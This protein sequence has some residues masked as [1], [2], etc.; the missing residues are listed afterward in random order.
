MNKMRPPLA[1]NPPARSSPVLKSVDVLSAGMTRSMTLSSSSSVWSSFSDNNS[2]GSG[3]GVLG[4][5][6]ISSQADPADY[7]TCIPQHFHFEYLSSLAPPS[8]MSVSS[9]GGSSD[10]RRYGGD[11]EDDIDED[12]DVIWKM[13][14][15]KQGGN[16]T[17]KSVSFI[18]RIRT[19]KK[20][21]ISN[22]K[23]NVVDGEEISSSSETVGTKEYT[24]T[25]SW[26]ARAF[27]KKIPRK[28]DGNGIGTIRHGRSATVSKIIRK[29][30]KTVGDFRGGGRRGRRRDLTYYSD[31]S[32][33]DHTR[34]F[35]KRYKLRKLLGTGGFSV[36][37]KC[38][39]RFTN[40]AYAVKSV[41]I[42]PLGPKDLELLRSEIEV[43]RSLPHHPR[44]AAFIDVYHGGAERE[45][46]SPIFSDVCRIIVEYV[47]GGDLF[48]R[49]EE[50]GAYEE[51][52][53]RKICN[54]L[55]EGVKVCHDH[56][57]VH[58]DLKLENILLVSK[59]NDV[60]IKICDFGCAGFFDGKKLLMEQCGTFSYMAPEIILGMPYGFCVD[61]WS[62]GVIVYAILSGGHPFS[63]D[64]ARAVRQ[65]VGGN[66]SMEKG[67]W[68]HI[69]PAAKEL[70]RAM[71]T[72]EPRKRSD[73]DS[74]SQHAWLRATPLS[75][76]NGRNT[77]SQTASLRGLK[78]P[79]RRTFRSFGAARDTDDDRDV[80]SRALSFR[81]LKVPVP[82]RKMVRSLGPAKDAG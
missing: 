69:S 45:G 80:R 62:L 75:E 56:G 63:D 6:G 15:G 49:L 13:R 43:L 10:L 51:H 2:S 57:I 70:V 52:R 5:G 73:I 77:P 53:A 18:P 40:R 14:K 82:K 76:D 23:S 78:V 68:E 22:W 12:E 67:S 79:K 36:V 42:A 74:L 65:I 24:K 25:K 50:K 34:I 8:Y 19:R 11:D 48:G 29:A 30:A 16:G 27:A 59:E 31:R 44:I 58:R 46:G 54:S 41:S 33:E 9:A 47:R 38:T 21:T 7:D 60:D 55:F 71:L 72:V 64:E 61:I 1:Q 35:E 81:R 26:A 20:H 4:V 37:H 66:Y 3:G 28:G 32:F 39:H 17:K